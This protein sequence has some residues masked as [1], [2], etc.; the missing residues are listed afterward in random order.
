MELCCH[1]VHSHVGIEHR[2]WGGGG[3]TKKGIF[4][5]NPTLVDHF[6]HVKYTLHF[7]E[8][9]LRISSVIQCVYAVYN[10]YTPNTILF[11]CWPI[12][13]A[14]RPCRT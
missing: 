9:M 14:T 12:E 4:L 8:E 3:T 6:V 11:A 5:F 13:A 7:F 1:E 10:P 2:H